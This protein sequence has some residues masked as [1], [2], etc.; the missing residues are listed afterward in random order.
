MMRHDVRRDYDIDLGEILATTPHRWRDAWDVRSRFHPPTITF[1]RTTATLP[2]SV[3]GARCALQ[4]AHCG[5]H[6]LRHMRTLDDA[7]AL[8]VLNGA[9]S[10]LI[11]GGC[12]AAGRVPVIEHLPVLRRL[13]A[14]RRLN[15]HLGLIDEETMRAVAP[16]ADVVSFDVVGDAAT[17]REVY[18]LDV[19]LAIYM[20]TLRTMRRHARVVPHITVGLRGGQL[21]GEMA[22]VS[23]LAAEGVDTLVFIVLI[24]TEGTAF[25]DRCPPKVADVADVLLQ[26]RLALPQARLLLGCMRPHGVYRQ[27][28][29]EVA[30]RAGINGIVNP[31]RVA[32]RV[33]EA[34]GLEAT[35]GNECCSLD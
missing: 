9:T 11:S 30:V 20:A 21:S 3:T 24:P 17:A 25:A 7:A 28:L 23:A 15:W 6:Y 1:D 4:C 29:D 5:G 12:D 35:W 32:E 18:G 31:T 33:A 13:G 2:I 34:L 10:L 27:A 14:G 22:A 8:G 26:A 19:D 16:L